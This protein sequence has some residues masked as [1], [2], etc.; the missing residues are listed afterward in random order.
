MANVVGLGGDGC[1]NWAGSA[2]VTAGCTTDCL[3]CFEEYLQGE[4]AYYSPVANNA[5]HAANTTGPCAD[6]RFLLL[7][8]S[9][10]APLY[11]SSDPL[12][13]SSRQ[14]GSACARPHVDTT[15]SHHHHP[16]ARAHGTGSLVTALRPRD[17]L[18]HS[19]PYACP[20]RPIAPPRIALQ[21][22]VAPHRPAVLHYRSRRRSLAPSR[23]SPHALAPSTSGHTTT[24]TTQV[25]SSPVTP[26]S[27]CCCALITPPTRAAPGPH[28][29]T[30]SLRAH[31]P[32]IP[33][34]LSH[35]S[36]PTR[37][38]ARYSSP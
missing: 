3:Y 12:H 23:R 36:T 17:L 28:R 20:L 38:Y 16:P 29:A 4:G 35:S 1:A 9:L 11:A 22:P 18:R 32:A 15:L 8:S 30:A 31:Q 25:H 34:Q 2:V 13:L 19:H 37:S 10:A 7:S 33:Q 27:H 5:T 6:Y 21:A 14:A 24:T 26:S